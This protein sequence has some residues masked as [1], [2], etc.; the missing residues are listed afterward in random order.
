MSLI[1]PENLAEVLVALGALLSGIG[2][3]ALWKIRKEPPEIG[4]PEA[5]KIA[6]AE[7]TAA[8]NALLYSFKGMNGQFEENNKLFNKALALVEALVEESRESRRDLSASREHLSAIRDA[9]NR[10]GP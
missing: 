5:L 4:T 1:T 10:R 7:T 3:W 6:L 8:L 9:I 2:G